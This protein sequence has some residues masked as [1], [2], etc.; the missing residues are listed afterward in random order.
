LLSGAIFALAIFITQSS[1]LL[2]QQ[3]LPDEVRV[4]GG[5]YFPPAMPGSEIRVKTQSVEVTVVVRDARG[6]PIAGLTQED[7]RVFDDGKERS[8][9]A[10]TVETF[11]PRVATGKQQAAPAEPAKGDEQQATAGNSPTTEKPARRTRYI[12]LYFDDEHTQPGDLGRAQAAAERFVREALAPEDRV[13]IFTSSSTVS[14][15]FTNDIPKIA[16]AIDGMKAHV[17][18]S[19]NGFA[20]CPRI[21]PYE[22]FLISNGLDPAAFDAAVTEARMCNCS[23]AGN[24]DLNCYKSQDQVVRTQADQTWGQARIISENTLTAIR[25]VINYLAKAPG[26]RMLLIASSGFLAGTTELEQQQDR[27]IAEALRAGVVINALDA[28]GLYAEPPGRPFNSGPQ[29]ILPAATFFFELRSLGDRLVTAGAPMANF[30]ASTGCI[31]F[32]N[33][34]DLDLGMREIG[35]VPAVSYLLSFSPDDVQANGKYHKLKV[36]VTSGKHEYVQARPGYFAPGK[37]VI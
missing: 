31:F 25:G 19:E 29:N 15:D 18:I 5:P 23:D 14:L 8:I 34:N 22:A 21:T 7:F 35:M 33:R 28:K 4:S 36:E 9:S 16:A 1:G 10:F 37:N 2:A 11:K 3:I 26:D 24:F 27:I 20:Q 13:A 30:A 32:H 6:H 17:R 12:A